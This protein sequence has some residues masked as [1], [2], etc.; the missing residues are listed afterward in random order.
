MQGNKT[1]VFYD[2]G[3]PLCRREINHYRRLDVRHR[4]QWVDI[5]QRLGILQAFDIS[6]EKAMQQLH[7]LYRDGRLLTGAFAFAALWSELP[8]YW[9]LAK[10]LRLPGL[11]AMVD[12]IYQPIARL[13][14]RMRRRRQVCRQ[15]NHG[16]EN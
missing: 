10:I 6:H 4:I 2:G 1:M 3:C 8:Y 11:L 5:T 7:V 9:I 12:K 16:L 13:R 14:L 15:I